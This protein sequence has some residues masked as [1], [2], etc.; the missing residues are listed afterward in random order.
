MAVVNLSLLP[1]AA[2]ISDRRGRIRTITPSL[3]GV[4]AALCV[5]AVAG[6]VSW[7]LV[8]AGILA[9]STAISGPAPAAFAA[10]Q[11]PEQMRGLSLGM[12]RTAGDIGLL[13]GPPLLGWI[14]DVGGY[15]AAFGLNAAV[16][17][18]AAVT[19]YSSSRRRA[20]SPGVAT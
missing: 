1:F 10:D 18:L 16:T 4:A 2:T 14:A 12:F 15:G 3:L 7:F 17:A 8:G 13:V 20:R 19:F 11:A 5:I 9:L 6:D